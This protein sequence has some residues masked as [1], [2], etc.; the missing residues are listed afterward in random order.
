MGLVVAYFKWPFIAL[1]YTAALG[2]SGIG[3]VDIY[4]QNIRELKHTTTMVNIYLSVLKG[5]FEFEQ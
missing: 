1:E 3:S 5:P 4:V 2:N